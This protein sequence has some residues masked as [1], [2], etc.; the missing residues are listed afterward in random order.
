MEPSRANRSGGVMKSTFKPS[1]PMDIPM[2]MTITATL[3]EWSE[4][5]EHLKDTRHYAAEGKLL[6]AIRVMTRKAVQHFDAEGA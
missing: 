6:E 4:I 1:S 3:F 2:T 5:A